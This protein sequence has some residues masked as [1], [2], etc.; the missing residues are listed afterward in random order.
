MYSTAA[1][2]GESF[3]QIKSTRQTWVKDAIKFNIQV[4]FVI[5]E[6]KDNETQKELESEAFQYKDMIQFGF[7]EDY[8][9]CT[10]KH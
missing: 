3:N 9:N 7:R 6:P 5:A 8:Y 10:L 2:S 1:T 4:F